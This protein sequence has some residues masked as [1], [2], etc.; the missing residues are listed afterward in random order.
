M[1]LNLLQNT[2]YEALQ[3]EIYENNLVYEFKF[4]VNFTLA[5][6]IIV[7]VLQAWSA[8]ACLHQ[9]MES[10]P[11]LLI[12]LLHSTTKPLLP[13]LVTLALDYLV[14]TECELVSA[15]VRVLENGVE[16]LQLVKVGTP[17]IY[18]SQQ[19]ISLIY[20]QPSCVIISLLLAMEVLSTPLA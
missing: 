3:Y 11:M 10:S 14:E 1:T 7:I 4:L 8:E 6:E 13:T 20:I 15:L 18:T 2:F 9:L 16:L 12:P 17:N 19:F 5:A